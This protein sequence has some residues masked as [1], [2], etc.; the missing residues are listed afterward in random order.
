M[1]RTGLAEAKRQ[2]SITSRGGAWLRWG[3][4]LPTVVELE[5]HSHRFK[6]Q[7]FTI[8]TGLILGYCILPVGMDGVVSSSAELIQSL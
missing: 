4:P 6:V 1:R 2:M 3:M 8:R 5:K 7:D